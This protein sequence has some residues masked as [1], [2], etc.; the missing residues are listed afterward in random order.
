MGRLLTMTT[1]NMAN[2]GS[3]DMTYQST[4]VGSALQMEQT[5]SGLS[6]NAPAAL[7]TWG[8]DDRYRLTNETVTI[9][10]PSASNV[11][12]STTYSW[13][14]ADN[15]LSK[16]V[17]GLDSSDPVLTI[18]FDPA[19]ALNQITGYTKSSASVPLATVVEFAHDA[20]GARTNKFSI[21]GSSS[22]SR[23]LISTTKTIDLS[24]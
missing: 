19:N 5:S 18:I 8:Y 23:L 11:Q 7:T 2:N 4:A 12:H 17:Y 21:G 3:F 14:D 10:S 1:T 9:L 13:D 16:T 20:N 24:L 6:A 15:R 22:T